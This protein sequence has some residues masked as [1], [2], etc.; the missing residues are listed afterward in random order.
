MTVAI[1]L[2]CSDGVI[3]ASDSMLSTGTL[4]ANMQKVFALDRLR[5]LWAG[6]G[7][8]Y[9]IEAVGQTLQQ[10]A[11]DG[12]A[13]HAF[14]QSDLPAIRTALETRVVQGAMKRCYESVLATSDE[15]KKA[16]PVA[17]FLVLGWSKQGAHA[18]IISTDGQL[19]WRH[20]VRFCAIGSGGTFALVANA[21]MAHYVE[22]ADLTVEL[23]LRLAFR[24]IET[25]CRVSSQL[26]G[27]PVQLGVV[28][29][30]GARVLT[31]PEV[32]AVEEAV[33]GWKT[34]EAVTLRKN[35]TP[36]APPEPLPTMKDGIQIAVDKTDG[37]AASSAAS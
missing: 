7:A 27:P 29:A 35:I 16:Y 2:V 9:T 3:V 17:E 36:P 11:G 10:L 34:L 37:P 4:A 30:M 8:V 28:D 23:G 6:A 32:D 26:I 21:L 25:I 33:A 5:V 31:Q 19:N 18:T 15:Q 24:T 1:G 20:Q 14:M 13:S 12:K 22:G